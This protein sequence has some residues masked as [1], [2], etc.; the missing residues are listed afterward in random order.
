MNYQQPLFQSK[1]SHNPAEIIITSCF[2]SQEIFH[3]MTNFENSCA[4]AVIYFVE[5]VISKT[6]QTHID[7]RLLKDNTDKLM[8]AFPPY[9]GHWFLV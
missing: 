4:T 7:P 2:G 3:I 5:T 6:K 1:L 8:C 9:L